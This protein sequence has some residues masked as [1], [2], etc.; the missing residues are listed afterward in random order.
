MA[1]LPV[2]MTHHLQDI[3]YLLGNDLDACMATQCWP[4]LQDG[5]GEFGFLQLLKEILPQQDGGLAQ[6]IEMDLAGLEQIEILEA[7]PVVGVV[8]MLNSGKSSLVSSFL[9]AQGQKRVLCGGLRSE[10]TRRLVFWLPESWR[11]HKVYWNTFIELLERLSGHGVDYLADEVELAHRQY[12]NATESGNDPKTVPRTDHRTDPRTDK[13]ETEKSAVVL[14]ATDPALDHLGIGLLDCPDIQRSGHREQRFMQQIARLCHAFF[15]V[16]RYDEI[17]DSRYAELVGQMHQLMPGLPIYAMIN[18]I[19]VGYSSEQMLEIIEDNPPLQIFSGI[20]GAYD[21]KQRPTSLQSHLPNQE[22]SRF[23]QFFKFNHSSL[24]NPEPLS[25]LILKLVEQNHQNEQQQALWLSLQQNMQQGQKEISVE[26]QRQRQLLQERETLLLS[27]CRQQFFS[28]DGAALLLVSPA[29]VELL[30]QSFVRSAPLSLRFIL[31]SQRFLG[32]QIKQLIERLRAKGEMRERHQRVDAQHLT[33]QLRDELMDSSLRIELPESRQIEMAWE[34]VLQEM[35]RRLAAI[36]TR[37]G[38]LD[39]LTRKIWK[40]MPSKKTAILMIKSYLG[41]VAT[42]G[43][44]AMIPFDGGLSAGL[45]TVNAG[46]ITATLTF[47]QISTLTGLVGAGSIGTG[48]SS[49]RDLFQ[50]MESRLH[51][52]LLHQFTQISFRAFGVPLNI[53]HGGT[54]DS[55]IETLIKGD[56]LFKQEDGQSEVDS[57]AICL[58]SVN[59]RWIEMKDERWHR[60]EDLLRERLVQPIVAEKGS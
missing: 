25:E 27:L 36:D 21:F 57:E 2:V 48:M 12:N 15:C 59:L 33:R 44:V 42:L 43:A 8:G 3:Q 51:Q 4:H 18:A 1:D 58:L 54:H 24:S 38:E 53:G 7:M 30:Q 19:D 32:R 31:Q 37:D 29:L 13:S 34:W 28:A 56:P 46:G 45:A 40:E 35:E 60:V 41:A 16:G 39:T 20:Y 14:I 10:G 55:K 6:A 22:S 47:A 50:V 9:S 49:G 26:L 11:K 17:E 23:P 52:Q 5:K